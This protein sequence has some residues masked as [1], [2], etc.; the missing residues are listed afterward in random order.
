MAVLALAGITGMFLRHATA[1]A[2]W[3]RRVRRAGRR[4]PRACSPPLLVAYVLPTV[5]GTN[6]GYVQ[7]FLDAARWGDSRPA[8][9]A[10]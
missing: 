1:S 2:S 3:A 5:A 4:L 8:T 7:D 6:P 9:S 10:T